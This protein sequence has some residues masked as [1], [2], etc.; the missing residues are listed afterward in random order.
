MGP[1]ENLKHNITWILVGMSWI[2][3]SVFARDY[4][5]YVILFEPIFPKFSDFQ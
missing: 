2:V 3:A 1:L 5:Q 4:L